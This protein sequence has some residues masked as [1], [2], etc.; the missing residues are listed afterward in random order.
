[1]AKHRTT[2]ETVTVTFVKSGT[3]EIIEFLFPTSLLE[4]TD[5][6]FLTVYVVRKGQFAVAIERSPHMLSKHGDY[7]VITQDGRRQSLTRQELEHLL[8][9]MERANRIIAAKPLFPRKRR[10]P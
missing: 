6:L 3:M 2:V 10:K 7:V 8:D 4:H 1:M 9:R 5:S